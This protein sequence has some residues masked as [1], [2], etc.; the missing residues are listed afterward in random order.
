MYL[1]INQCSKGEIVK[2]ISEVFPDVRVS[3]L[4]QTLVIEPIH[5]SDLSALMIS[6]QNG[7]SVWKSYLE[8][9]PT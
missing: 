8:R 4:A 7:Y 9:L 1:S 6:P 3:I 2:E 5:L